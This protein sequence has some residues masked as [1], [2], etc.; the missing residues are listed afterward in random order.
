MRQNDHLSLFLNSSLQGESKKKW[1]KPSWYDATHAARESATAWGSTGSSRYSRDDD[2][3]QSK[4]SSSAKFWEKRLNGG[5]KGSQR[6]GKF[7]LDL[8]EA[9]NHLG[10]HVADIQRDLLKLKAE[11]SVTL[12]WSE[13]CY[14]IQVWKKP[15]NIRYVERVDNA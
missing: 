7:S 9:A 14:C 2:Y 8:C 12:F 3:A 1:G 10:C 6:A 11:K 13:Q 4:I 15:S 5:S